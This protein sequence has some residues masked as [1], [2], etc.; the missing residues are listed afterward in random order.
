MDA[1]K[2]L[3]DSFNIMHKELLE[4][5]RGTLGGIII[6][7]IA[8]L[9]L[10]GFVFPGATTLS[11]MPVGVVDLDNGQGSNAFITELNTLNK[12]ANN[13]M[14]LQNFTN[15]DTAKTQITQ[16]KLDGTYIIPQGFSYNLT[17]GQQAN[18]IFY[19]DNSNPQ[20]STQLESVASNSVN[21]INGIQATQNVMNTSTATNQTA[22]AQAAKV[23]IFPYS[24]NV[25][26]TIPGKTNNFNF[27]AP[28]LMMMIVMF[29]VMSALPEVISKES[30]K[31]TFDGLLSAPINQ[32]SILLGKTAA[33]GLR[34]LCQAAII[35]VLAVAIFG[36]TVNGSII[37]TFFMLVLGI[38]SFIGLGLIV[39]SLAKDQATGDTIIDLLVI[40][41]MFLSGIFIPLQTLPW[42]LQDIAKIIP[43]TYAADALRKIMLLNANI[44]DVMSQ[45]LILIGFGVVTMAIA[46]PIFRR[47][48][49]N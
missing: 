23:T 39:V 43:L 36:V 41:M 48:M 2:I 21:E 10:F 24:T 13:T 44:G 35:L 46:I 11:D 18:V 9:L 33:L 1:I 25:Q 22:N 45:T 7:P 34:G 29:S 31:G 8:F 16:G 14:S 38:F 5:D 6:M 19:V 26:T 49:Q 20:L 40:P 28:G 37:L 15:V 32:V 4:I 42:F 3:K 27:L 30:E 47:S 12:N 17:H